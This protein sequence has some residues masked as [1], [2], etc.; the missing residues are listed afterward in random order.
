ML[1]KSFKSIILACIAILT[2]C[3]SSSASAATPDKK[4]I[5]NL[6]VF[7]YYADPDSIPKYHDYREG[8]YSGTLTKDS[9]SCKK[10]ERSED[11]VC[12]GFYSGWITKK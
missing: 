5:T 2:I 11:Y 10:S 8:D 6:E 9:Q 4:K 7:Y 3:S 12:R 1:K